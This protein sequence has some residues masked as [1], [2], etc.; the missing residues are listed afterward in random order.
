MN[1][2]KLI[3]KD[4]YKGS[5]PKTDKEMFLLLTAVVVSKQNLR[6]VHKVYPPLGQDRRERILAEKETEWSE[7]LRTIILY[8]KE[9]KDF[10]NIPRK[11]G[12]GILS[13]RKDREEIAY[14]NWFNQMKTK[15]LENKDE[16]HEEVIHYT[17]ILNEMYEP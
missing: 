15:Y 11:K 12:D 1:K 4:W 6:L 16:W 3:L 13:F 8:I 9:E 2:R 7:R 10:L 5:L 14:R 17:A